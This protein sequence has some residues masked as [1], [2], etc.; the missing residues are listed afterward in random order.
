MRHM[1][2]PTFPLFFKLWFAFVALTII[3][4]FGT[5][6]YLAASIISSGPDGIG[7]AIGQFIKSVDEG[8]R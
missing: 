5:G 1:R 2:E 8:R 4:I 7:R 3:G 6:I